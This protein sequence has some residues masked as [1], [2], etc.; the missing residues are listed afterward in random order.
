MPTKS[1]FLIGGLFLGLGVL[2][3]GEF[4][5]KTPVS[6]QVEEARI[7]DREGLA[8]RRPVLAARWRS[9]SA[10]TRLQTGDWL[11]TG[12]RGA[13]AL[14]FELAA[15]A[16]ILLG[17]AT[18]IEMVGP[19][20]L[21]LYR[22]ELEIRPDPSQS[23]ALEGAGI[24]T[25]IGEPSVW[26][27]RN[28]QMM[29]LQQEPRW[30]T[31][32][33]EQATTEAMGSLLAN[34]D[35]RDVPLTIGYHKV[36]VDIRDQ[37]A[38]T[39]VEQS[40]KNHTAARLEGVFYFPLP[41]NASVSSFAMWIGNELVEGDIVEKQR[42]REIFETILREKRDPGLLEWSG[43]NIFK[44]RVFPIFP[45]SEKRIK[46]SYTEALPKHGDQYTYRYALQSELLRLNPLRELQIRVTVNSQEPLESVT[47][48]THDCRERKTEHGASVEFQAEEFVPESDFEVKIRVHPET[49][50]V[51]AI[52]SRRGKDGYFMLLLNSLDFLL[53][54]PEGSVASA[55]SSQ[56][57]D[58]WIVADTSGSMW[59]PQRD[60]Q[61]QFIEGLLEALGPDDRFTLYTVDTEL[62][63]AFASPVANTDEQRQLAMEFLEARYPLGWSD[64]GHAFEE[65][66]SR[67]QVGTQ[68]IYVGDG[69]ITTG[70]ADPAAFAQHL[71]RTYRGL[72]SV[73]AVIPGNQSEMLVLRALSNLG[74]GSVRQI[75][76]TTDAGQT[77]F[78]LLDEITAP[79][80]KS[81]E[82]E[83]AGVS[84]AAV[85]PRKLPNLARGKQQVVVGR[86]DTEGA[87]LEGTA[88]VRGVFRGRAF[89]HR[90]A[91]NF[92][93]TGVGNSFIPRLWARRHL[94]HL[95]LQGADAK[96]QERIIGLSEDFQIMTPYT[97]F[98]V[99][100]S[101]EDRERFQVQRQFRIRDGEEFFATGREDANFELLHQQMK[102]A[103]TWRKHLRIDLLRDISGMHRE[104][105]D[106]LSY[107]EAVLSDSAMLG[108]S[109]GSIRAGG[110]GANEMRLYRE[111]LNRQIPRRSRSFD[112][113]GSS[114]RFESREVQLQLTEL[115]YVDAEESVDELEKILEE[116]LLK[117]DFHPDD[118]ADL[119]LLQ[120]EENRG[121]KSKRNFARSRRPSGRPSQQGNFGRRGD[122]GR[123]N[124]SAMGKRVVMGGGYNQPYYDPL[125]SFFPQLQPA[126]EQAPW[127][128]DWPVEVL[129][130][131]Q[132]VDRR[133]W[134]R[135]Q[136]GGL[137]VQ[138]ENHW[139]N[140]R[141]ESQQSGPN[142]YLLSAERWWSQ[143]ARL[144]G[145]SNTLQWFDGKNRGMVFTTWWL[146]RQF[147][148]PEK[149]RTLESDAWMGPIPWYLGRAYLS[150]IQYQATVRIPDPEN[151]HRKSFVF[152]HPE[153]P[154]REYRVL[155]DANRKLI[156]ESGWWQEN[157]LQARQVFAGFVQVSGLYWPQRMTS[158]GHDGEKT[159][160]TQIQIQSL[161]PDAFTRRFEAVTAPLGQAVLLDVDLP[162]LA[163]AK[164]TEQD[165]ESAWVLLRHYVSQHRWDEAK[166]YVD[167]VLNWMGERAGATALQVVF[168]NES[169]RHEELRLK[170]QL[171]VADLVENPRLEDVSAAEWL[172]GYSHGLEKGHELHALLSSYGPIYERR[173]QLRANR[174]RWELRMAR[175]LDA[176][177]LPIQAFELRKKLVQTY[178][179][180][181]EAHTEYANALLQR[182]ELDQAV[183]V[184]R[185][186]EQDHGPWE[187]YQLQTFQNNLVMCLWNGY[188]LESLVEQL[189]SWDRQES[190]AA[191]RFW[192]HYLSA[193]LLLD[194]EREA[195]RLAHAWIQAAL[196]PEELSE[197]VTT[198]AQAG[199]AYL[200]GNGYQFHRSR[201]EEKHVLWLASAVRGMLPNLD[202]KNLL[203]NILHNHRFRRT[204]A[205]QNELLAIFTRLRGQAQ[206]LQYQVLSNYMNWVR[207]G[208]Y[209]Y[210]KPE[211]WVIVD[212]VVFDRWNQAEEGEEAQILRDLLFRYA[213]HEVKADVLRKEMHQA[214]GKAKHGTAKYALL[215]HLLSGSWS[216][217]IEKEILDLLPEIEVAAW[218]P[219]EDLKQRNLDLRA[220]VMYRF[221][222]RL[223][224]WRK[225]ALEQAIPNANNLSRLELKLEKSEAAKE[226]RSYVLRTLET[227]AAR[228]DWSALR[229]WIDLDIMYLKAK[230]GVDLSSVEELAL[231]KLQELLESVADSDAEEV[232]LRQEI[233]ADRLATTLT[234]RFAR[235]YEREGA[236][237]E[238]VEAPFRKLLEQ[239]IA[240]HSKI[241][242]GREHLFALLV[243]LK[244]NTALESYLQGWYQGGKD[245]E[246]IIWGIDLAYLK[247][248]Q[249]DLQ[250]AID[251]FK[252][253]IAV[254]EI[255]F[256]EFRSMADWYVALG[257][258]AAARNARQQS[259]ETLSAEEIG[260]RLN[261]A[262]HQYERRGSEVPDELDPEIA[263]Q[264]I[265]LFRKS[266]Y[267]NNEL[268][269]LRRLYEATKD[270]RL[271][272]CLAES[273]VGQS[274]QSIYPFLGD[275]ERVTGMIHDEATVARLEQGIEEVR[276]RELTP[277]DQRALY[278]LEFLIA[279]RA[280]ELDHGTEDH[281]L[282]AT[283]A[284]KRAIRVGATDDNLAW[285]PGESVLMAQFLQHHFVSRPPSLR[286]LQLD[287]F[288]VL[289]NQEPVGSLP[290]LE[291][292]N[293]F[294]QALA[295]DGQLEEAARLLAGALSEYQAEFDGAIPQHARQYLK[296]YS[297][298]LS[299][300]GEYLTAEQVWQEE[301]R[302]APN[303]AHFLWLEEQLL[304]TYLAALR[305]DSRVTL[306]SGMEFYGGLKDK[307]ILS[308]HQ[309]GNEYAAYER[310]RLLCEVFVVAHDQQDKRTVQQDFR[311]FAY[312]QLPDV[313]ALYQYRRGQQMV[314]RVAETLR[315]VISDAAALSFM[316][317]RAET[318]P[319]WLRLRDEDF[320]GRH[321]W[322]L[323]NYFRRSSGI[324]HSLQERVLAIVLQELRLDMRTRRAR[325]RAIY[326]LRHSHGWPA[327]KSE[328][329]QAALQTFEEQPLSGAS[330]QHIG[331]YL[332]HGAR[333]PKPAMDVLFTAQYAGVL[334][335]EGRY[336][337]CE[338]LHQ[339]GQHKE[340]LPLVESLVKEVPHEV[341]YHHMLILGYAYSSL[342][343][344]ADQAYLNAEKIFKEQK[345]WNESVVASLAR[346]CLAA[347]QVH[348]AAG[349]FEEAVG[350]RVRS[351]PN[352][353]L[354][355][356]ALSDYYR[357]LSDARSQ[358]GQTAAAVDAAAGAIVVWAGSV[359]ERS[360]A[361]N[362]LD[363][364]LL[365]A[366]DFEEF[367]QSFE[368]QVQESGLE[369]P[370]L[371]KAI[372]KAYMVKLEYKQAIWNF[373]IAAAVRPE[374]LETHQFLVQC[375]DKQEQK[376]KALQRLLATA[377][378][379]GHDVSLYQDLGQRFEDLKQPQEAE[380]AYTTMVEALPQE[381]ESHQNLAAVRKRQGRLQEAADQWREVIRIRTQEP[382]GYLGLAETLMEIG[383]RE[384]AEEI[385]QHLIQQA[386]PEHFGNVNERSRE[387]LRNLL[388]SAQE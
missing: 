200:L 60:T 169:R 239:A 244:R 161:D 216:Q 262:R 178:P 191:H 304:R 198:Q 142:E 364:V 295:K 329:V 334:P 275:L 217:Q 264:L 233:L 33:R 266:P 362:H 52:T 175:A 26:G 174:F 117:D 186:A 130:A 42:A 344:L 98:L 116:P 79:T 46:L 280:L 48:P 28:G 265:A 71:Q 254:D 213:G 379:H 380:R 9:V 143:S 345:S 115:G 235:R 192:G 152:K 243:I 107:D 357:Q 370:I 332:Y 353:G 17:P 320:W 234:Y 3:G 315:K 251:I 309:A 223:L 31:G 134:L 336:Q 123:L 261:A 51:S 68:V 321:S 65:L 37:I 187:E 333:A 179:Q 299:R 245:Y 14:R 78:Q 63:Q 342:P 366:A 365:K 160:E 108:E 228:P 129:E 267:P 273:V 231:Q 205:A 378:V 383:D 170:L 209:W 114:L 360:R 337:L 100:E 310:L 85:Y 284:L 351:S 180:E 149:Q 165:P 292:R 335:A 36:Q 249:G 203:S 126:V 324:A 188:R 135:R 224:E 250:A 89:E 206:S 305:A 252:E 377:R 29:K 386:W 220:W 13:N 166:V 330:A 359:E 57:L 229:N 237:D 279:R 183:Q 10:G 214:T 387:L 104:V 77:A 105:M 238:E 109:F 184:L 177:H 94:D 338:Y 350:L 358:L 308:M 23:V 62:R 67:A 59:G 27:I 242:N 367:V 73:H 91:L 64:L 4:G 128:Q 111:S 287:Q 208:E 297:D 311:R 354:G 346:A 363:E 253:I 274:S 151:P 185:T 316:V 44:A 24:S 99:L 341:K 124:S 232:L 182:G 156:L 323:S 83:F 66:L 138:T 54:D 349:L 291:I 241:L 322:N 340:S 303:K 41:P 371:R 225:E 227:L 75:D 189:E 176:M 260:T 163:V 352:R 382:I 318:E 301:M 319:G 70:S 369:N 158:F 55:E 190:R 122:S 49:A 218:Y 87:A 159:S 276:I 300:L 356:Q 6:G 290:R 5:S 194:R 45:Y 30:L 38:R 102:A 181:H 388:H 326:D 92:A 204:D 133:D 40:F 144:P 368:E 90:T 86:F 32:Y 263:D 269:R 168:L 95:L 162:E 121:K 343:D 296:V 96:M 93:D 289:S 35:G 118:S 110:G 384:E 20:R 348:R 317:S 103:E 196:Q 76:A 61:L 347:G 277:V 137:F 372:G 141:G 53:N 18:Q 258:A 106:W 125:E 157:E 195:E 72:G 215:N 132:A 2:F 154:K 148:V 56:P 288:V 248:E 50:P 285:Q 306:G 327:K 207:A 255:D 82:L 339:A 25:N 69:A 81:M 74:N 286:K 193:L 172:L 155:F 119:R 171:A 281:A 246:K 271:L 146:G 1:L 374:D 226:A 222:D 84:A 240:S 376:Q 268:W 34:V 101:E 22:G 211:D 88:I 328:F 270:F 145:M 8:S 164:Q 136:S 314:G 282:K 278:L 283:E 210:N 80:I 313:L 127:N 139:T 230:N 259:W 307:I 361:L 197:R 173:S 43:G 7:L 212:G 16:E 375:F 120:F 373:E 147:E 236:F 202:R 167:K 293:A 325:G 221:T 12:A 272:G 39:V 381:S 256:P 15:G 97:S 355:D 131:L 385:L 199:A 298:F 219:E 19:S 140:R 113:S 58:L 257:D 201:L 150:L 153:S 247:A 21:K 11:K 294:A 112:E 47:S 331:Y 312:Q 302:S